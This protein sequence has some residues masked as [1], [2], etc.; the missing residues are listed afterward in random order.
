MAIF[1][2]FYASVGLRKVSFIFLKCK[3]HEY[4]R[5]F[6]F[7]FCGLAITG[8]FFVFWF[9]FRLMFLIYNNKVDICVSLSVGPDLYSVESKTC[10]AFVGEK[11]Q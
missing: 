11:L 6:L 1:I 8:I 9:F 5:G 7:I 3:N 2:A 4:V 10:S